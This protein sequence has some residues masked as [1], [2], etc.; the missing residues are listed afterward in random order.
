MKIGILGSRGIPNNYGGFEQL[1]QYLAVAL[2][3]IGHEVYVYSSHK[4]P[5]QEKIW[6]NVHIIHTYDPEHRLGTFGQFIYDL[7]SIR[8]SRKRNFDILLQL[9]Y[10]SSS[11]WGAFLPRKS[12]IITNMDGLE[13][14]RSKYN[15]WVRKFLTYAEKWGVQSSDY[16]IADSLG[17]Q[18][19]LREKYQVESTFIAY[20][21]D[22]FKN[23]DLNIP[24][25]YNLLPYQYSMLIARLEPENNIETILSGVIQSGSQEPFLIIGNHQSAYGEYLKKKFNADFIRFQGAIYDIQVLNNLRHYCKLYFHGHSVGGTN[26]SLLEAM[27]SGALI[28]AHNN[29]FNATILEENAYY[30]EEA[31]QISQ[32]M[33]SEISD[34]ERKNKISTNYQ[35]IE[36]QYQWP[37]IAAAYESLM[38]KCFQ[39]KKTK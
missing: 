8:D 6:K 2:S 13:W 26:P 4:H 14:K 25:Q 29:V 15:R 1:A 19:Y 30:F 20:G 39:T 23:P 18:N 37:Q 9:G 27:A 36:K 34:E 10:T 21:A 16:L 12:I 32:L 5:Y 28:C 31:L 11:I 35:K 33:Q 7:N 3:E 22:L 24:G 38:Q 17:I